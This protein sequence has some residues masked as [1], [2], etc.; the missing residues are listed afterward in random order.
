MKGESRILAPLA[1]F[2]YPRARECSLLSSVA[3]RERNLRVSQP[4]ILAKPLGP[5]QAESTR[6]ERCRKAARLGNFRRPGGSSIDPAPKRGHPNGRT[7]GFPPPQP[8]RRPRGPLRN[9]TH[10]WHMFTRQSATHSAGDCL[11]DRRLPPRGDLLRERSTAPDRGDPL[12]GFPCA[13]T[14]SRR[15]RYP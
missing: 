10:G 15:G 14:S 1:L 13:G 3:S 6:P 12:P 5:D 4:R 7:R 2:E 8:D 9:R 11:P